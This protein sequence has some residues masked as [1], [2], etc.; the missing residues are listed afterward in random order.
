MLDNG[1]VTDTIFGTFQVDK[2]NSQLTTKYE[3][4]EFRFEILELTSSSLQI[5]E[6][7]TNIVQR[8]R[9]L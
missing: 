8:Y 5:Q 2:N 7:G 4:K 1:K 3:N 6:K 9:R